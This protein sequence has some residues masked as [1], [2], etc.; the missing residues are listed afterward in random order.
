MTPLA[1]RTIDADHRTYE[2]LA[3]LVGT[4][5]DDQLTQPSGASEWTVAEVLS[6][7][8]SGAQITLDT[9]RAAQEGGQRAPDANEAVWARW[10]A[11][12]PRAQADG[13]VQ[14]GRELDQAY[15]ELNSTDR[16]DLR[17][18]MAFLPEPAGI[19]LFTGMR[20]N[21]AVLHAWDVE[22]AFHPTATIPGDVAA[23]LVEQYLGPLDFI[24]GFSAKADRL[25]NR[26][27]T[28]TVRTT[29]PSRTLG[30]RIRDQAELTEPPAQSDG[31]LRLPLG[32]LP[33]LLAGRLRRSDSIQVDGP[34]SL[35]DLRRV[36]PGY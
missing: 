5:T 36:F 11:M 13:Y 14:V 7:L 24:L 34:A 10:N 23:V 2:R 28:L 22:V 21:E 18:P 1:D 4:L 8:G 29:A 30:L 3:R 15:A 9:L 27:V 35:E 33:R 31:E 26:P 12:S 32:A 6:H 20:L 25:S 16:A 17:V 19:D